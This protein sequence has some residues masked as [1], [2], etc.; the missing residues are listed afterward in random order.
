MQTIASLVKRILV[1]FLAGVLV[2]VTTACAGGADAT[3]P[4][5]TGA[6]EQVEETQAAEEAP[7]EEEIS[8]D[9]EGEEEV[10]EVAEVAETEEEEAVA[11]ADYEVKMGS[12]SGQ[13]AFVPQK[14]TVHPGETVRWV[15]NKVP[16]HNI[17]FD[18]TKVSGEQK[19]YAKSLS[20]QKLLNKGSY[21]ITIP[22]DMPPGEYP[23]YCTPHRGAGMLGQLIVE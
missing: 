5:E 2:F 13:L 22:D 9:S 10:A 4:E 20:S 16:P 17:V 6:P 23:Y 11:G 3:A 12:D 14:L 8:E 7:A 15:I 21:E 1:V 18:D 19:E